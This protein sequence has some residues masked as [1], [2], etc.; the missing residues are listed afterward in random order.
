[1]VQFTQ[2]RKVRRSSLT[3][4]QKQACE[5]LCIHSCVHPLIIL[6]R[7][8]IQF[9]DSFRQGE[10]QI[11]VMKYLRFED[12][13]SYLK[14]TTF[15]IDDTRSVMRQLLQALMYIHKRGIVHRGVKLDHVLLKSKDPIQ[16]KLAGFSL[17]K[18]ITDR[19]CLEDSASQ[20]PECYEESSR[21]GYGPDQW[22][23]MVK[24]HYGKGRLPPICGT[25]LDVWSAGGLCCQLTWNKTLRYSNTS[26]TREDKEMEFLVFLRLSE[27][28]EFSTNDQTWTDSLGLPYNPEVSLFPA[29]DA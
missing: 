26:K 28:L 24:Q 3:N 9:E 10:T 16:I 4:N 22:V 6:Q 23:E 5:F 14:M 29:E 18:R 15:G 8:V 7:R 1:M 21:S 12:L 20:S 19:S 27:T 25:P 17:A 13:G 11:L 2:T